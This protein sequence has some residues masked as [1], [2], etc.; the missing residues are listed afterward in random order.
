MTGFGRAEHATDTLV[1]RVEV[2]S[3]NRKQGEVL[4]Q[5]PRAYAELDAQLRKFA[6]TKISRGRLTIGINIEQANADQGSLV[7]DTEKVT[8]LKSELD[9]LSALLGTPIPLTASEIL[10]IPEVIISENQAASAEDALL[11][12]QPALE[13]ALANLVGMRAKEGDNL[14]QDTLERLAFLE[15]Q[16][17][18]IQAHA[19]S[20]LEKYRSNLHRKLK[21]TGL[22]V[23]LSDERVLKE[24]GLF[25]ERCDIAEELTRLHSHLTTFR[26]YLDSDQAIGRSLDFLCQELNREFNTIG[27][28]ANDATL[29]QHVVQSKTE[30][31]KIRE[32][33]QNVE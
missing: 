33:I 19:P 5:M 29:A 1:A 24:I 22:E 6:L 13:A 4:I 7:L 12:I 20:V 2:S 16:A 9:R 23:D 3:I 21:D 31:E 32:Q 17:I 15:Q 18:E 26:E 11:A 30:L 27:S 14:K 25:A 28:K 10:R 8:S